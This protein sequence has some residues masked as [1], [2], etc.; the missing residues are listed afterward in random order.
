MQTAK[1]KTLATKINVMPYHTKG[2]DH[3][4]YHAY[5]SCF[6]TCPTSSYTHDPLSRK[7]FSFPVHYVPQP[8]LIPSDLKMKLRFPKSHKSLY[9]LHAL[10]STSTKMP[11]LK[12]PS[13]NLKLFFHLS[14]TTSQNRE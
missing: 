4:L 13:M 6:Y 3:F 8:K 7:Y 1:P 9:S 14:H 11:D 5:L 2:T 12:R 10:K